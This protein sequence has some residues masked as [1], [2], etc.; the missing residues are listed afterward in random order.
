ML[1]YFTSQKHVYWHAMGLPHYEEITGSSITKCAAL[2]FVVEKSTHPFI[3]LKDPV[4]LF[5][6]VLPPEFQTLRFLLHRIMQA[7]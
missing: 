2:T 7:R 5:C 4:G 3:V 6:F 1:A